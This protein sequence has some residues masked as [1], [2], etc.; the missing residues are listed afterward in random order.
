[1]I[2]VTAHPH[3]AI[4]SRC[5][6]AGFD[7]VLR[8]PASLSALRQALRIE[9]AIRGG[10][11]EQERSTPAAT[12]D[13]GGAQEPAG[14]QIRARFQRRESLLLRLIEL[15][16]A[17]SAE[18]HERLRLAVESADAEA[19]ARVVHR[20]QGSSSNFGSSDLDEAFAKFES[21]LA[22]EGPSSEAFAELSGSISRIERVLRQIGEELSRERRPSLDRTTVDESP[23]EALDG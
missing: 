16:L 1:L 5:L 15:Y 10:A 3:E 14:Q 21:A 23:A 17:E 9:S 11:G 19:I 7:E 8:K 2:A 13:Q 6:E 4:R 20:W 18:L 12:S 22:A